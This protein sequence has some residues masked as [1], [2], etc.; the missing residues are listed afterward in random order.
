M[1]EL[2]MIMQIPVTALRSNPNNPRSDVGDVTELADSMKNLGVLEPLI[3]VA[4]VGELTG[5]PTGTYTIVA[6]HRRHAAAKLAG[7]D[8]V[9]CIVRS[10]TGINQIR[11]M[12]IENIV[13]ENMTAFDEAQ[14]FQMMIDL[15]DTPADI[16]ERTGFSTTTVRRRLKMAELDKDKLREVATDGARQLSLG[17]FDRLA[18]IEDLAERNKVLD[19]IGTRDFDQAMSQAISKQN[20]AKNLPTVKAWLKEHKAKAIKSSDSWGSKYDLLNSYIYID[21]LGTKGNE[22]PKNPPSPLFYVLDGRY[23]RL[24]KKHEKPPREKKPPEV[25]E[26]ERRIREAWEKVREKATL[27]YGLRKEFISKLTVTNKNREAILRGAL[28]SHILEAID[29]NSPNRDEVAAA[30]GIVGNSW[31][32]DRGVK[33]FSAAVTMEE[34]ALP[35]VIYELFGDSEKRDGTGHSYQANYP[36]YTFSA[37]LE[38]L[39]NWLEKLGYEP[40][41]EEILWLTGMHECFHAG[42][43]AEVASEDTDAADGEDQA[44]D[45]EC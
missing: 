20:V 43:Q 41:S 5:D 33:T 34:K 9:P 24:F 13:R 37:V 10:M 44:E 11:A 26:K 40:S 39:Y 1:S 6:G 35:L 15:G 18:E 28:Y 31:D 4:D 14:G 25:L 19:K 12:M 32:S 38:L 29:Y 42:E 16:A 3:V 36:A 7:L 2:E 27:F 45:A 21:V 17:E 8:T 30:L 23:L 22:L